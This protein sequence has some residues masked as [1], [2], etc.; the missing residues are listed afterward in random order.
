[1]IERG[2]Y[3]VIELAPS[4]DPDRLDPPRGKRYP[5]VRTKADAMDAI[6]DVMRDVAGIDDLEVHGEDEVQLPYQWPSRDVMMSSLAAVGALLQLPVYLLTDVD[7]CLFDVAITNTGMT[8]NRLYTSCRDPAHAAR[9][10][11]LS[12]IAPVTAHDAVT[13][14]P[15]IGAK[16]LQPAPKHDP[17]SPLASGSVR[18]RQLAWYERTKYCATP[19]DV[20]TVCAAVRDPANAERRYSELRNGFYHF[21]AKH[22][23]PLVHET[24]IWALQHEDDEMAKTV[25][26][27][28][29][30]LDGLIARLPQLIDEASARGDKRTVARMKKLK[31]EAE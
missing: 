4:R 8:A 11:E 12:E 26:Y 3:D 24:F 31:S 6:L 17:A 18:E 1:M 20:A 19:P 14:A 7:G 29:W 25:T 27:V 16:P 22:D 9:F 10:L 28:G 15:L 23:V 30:R 13:T 5:N 21:L 2:A